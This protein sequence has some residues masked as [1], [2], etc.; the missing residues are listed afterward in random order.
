MKL[1]MATSNQDKLREI[2]QMLADSDITVVSM[3]EAGVET[4]IAETGT[5]FEE[6]AV[7]KARTVCALTGETALA[8]DSGLV[9]DCL[10][11]QPGI[12]SSRFMGE[13]TPY[14]E[15]NRAILD[16][17]KDVPEE[18]RSA[19][20]VCAMAIAYPDGSVKTCKGVMEGRIAWEIKGE[21]GFGY[22]PIFYLPERGCTS[23]QLPPE[24]KNAISHRGKALRQAVQI[25][26]TGS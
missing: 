3:K 20:F 7:I 18:K 5:T 16:R 11:G 14:P 25:L 17:I 23:A 12:Y 8:D 4:D 10:D 6:N 24:E 1:I 15:K 2:R 22:D 26:K 9:I 21:G 19:R 13:H